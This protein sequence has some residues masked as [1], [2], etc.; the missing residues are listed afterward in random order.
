VSSLVDRKYW[1]VM[2]LLRVARM[3][4][5]MGIMRENS[6]AFEVLLSDN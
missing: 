6:A 3:L 2:P 5:A 4:N 1:F